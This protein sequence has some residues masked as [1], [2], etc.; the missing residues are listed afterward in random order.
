MP[1]DVT[2]NG[3]DY[4]NVKE[5]NEHG[6]SWRPTADVIDKPTGICYI[7]QNGE[8]DVTKYAKVIVS[9]S[10]LTYKDLQVTFPTTIKVGAT[11]EDIRNSITRA[12]VVINQ[13]TTGVDQ[14]FV[15]TDYSTIG[16]ELSS[17]STVV[18]GGQTIMFVYYGATMTS[19]IT[20]SEGKAKISTSG[21]GFTI[22]NLDSDN[23]LWVTNNNLSIKIE[24]DDGYRFF[25]G[26]VTISIKQSGSYQNI[27]STR[28]V[29]SV[30]DPQHVSVVVS[31][32]N[33]GDEFLVAAVPVALSDCATLVFSC[34]NAKI[35]AGGG[36]TRNYQTVVAATA[37][38]LFYIEADEGYAFL[39]VTPTATT[40]DGSTA[41]LQSTVQ[42]KTGLSLYFTNLK[43]GVTYNISVQAYPA[44]N[45]SLTGTNTNT[46]SI[47]GLN[48]IA[49]KLP[50]H[51]TLKVVTLKV[52]PKSGY[53]LGDVS[54][55]K[56]GLGYAN[57]SESVVDNDKTILIRGLS[58]YDSILFYIQTTKS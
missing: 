48:G 43:G 26:A 38:P 52:S 3:I 23:K 13:G 2:I 30:D 8:Y 51:P 49:G 57:F 6:V 18:A 58:Q 12:T 37:N 14:P 54:I 50:I 41:T 39:D 34:T 17:G 11:I 55:M 40:S 20:G 32:V 27:T 31:G 42:N 35:T 56:N 10:N 24:A 19:T 29:I 28:C 22:D 44:I 36:N 1:V 21:T 45:I 9:A 47:D 16:I 7:T 4:K 15:I 5:L 33:D 25:S 46:Y 53:T